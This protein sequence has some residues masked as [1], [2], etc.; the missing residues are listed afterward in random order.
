MSFDPALHQM[1]LKVSGY[2][3]I[4]VGPAT[5]LDQQGMIGDF[6]RGTEASSLSPV[7]SRLCSDCSLTQDHE[8][9]PWPRHQPVLLCDPVAKGQI[10]LESLAST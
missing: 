8:R 3:L 4:V 9:L 6:Y 1:S 5:R 2:V 7:A 10:P